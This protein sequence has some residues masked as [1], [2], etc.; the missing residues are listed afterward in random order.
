MIRD[1]RKKLTASELYLNE[2]MSI[3]YTK[4]KAI[5]FNFFDKDGNVR[6][7]NGLSV[8]NYMH[9][10]LTCIYNPNAIKIQYDGTNFAPIFSIDEKDGFLYKVELLG[11][12]YVCN[13]RKLNEVVHE[14]KV[15][16]TVGE[17]ADYYRYLS[18][19]TFFILLEHYTKDENG[20]TVVTNTK[21]TDYND[22]ELIEY[23]QEQMQKA[24]ELEAKKTDDTSLTE[25]ET[26]ETNE[27]LDEF[28]EEHET[29]DI[30]L[31]ERDLEEIDA[32]AS[33]EE[34]EDIFEID[35]ALAEILKDKLTEEPYESDYPDKI[36][37][38]DYQEYIKRIKSVNSDEQKDDASSEQNENLTQDISKNDS[39]DN[40][41]Q[42]DLESDTDED[43]DKNEQQEVEYEECD[44]NQGPDGTESDAFGDLYSATDTIAS[45]EGFIDDSV[46]Q[47]VRNDK[48]IDDIRKGDIV[49]ISVTSIMDIDQEIMTLKDFYC[50]IIHEIKKMRAIIIKRKEHML[51]QKSAQTGSDVGDSEKKEDKDINE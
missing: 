3:L 14:K 11:L 29:L 32:Y 31:S 44:D 42:S 26:S 33:D 51:R 46:Y 25:D 27:D 38:F 28:V 12:E 17:S 1:D 50:D 8:E 6:K 7:N 49:D 19:G 48:L 2:C 30:E 40:D 18:C 21:A 5:G 45:E 24:E 34:Y 37:D 15:V 39:K 16:R 20:I 36:E 43:Y 47:V 35:Y 23:V 4:I 10:T 41:M 13:D 9:G 22:N